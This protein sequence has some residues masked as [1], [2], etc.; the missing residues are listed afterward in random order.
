MSYDA[1]GASWGN[2]SA[3]GIAWVHGAT[4]P[5]DT[6]DDVDERRKLRKQD[7]DYS[8]ARDALRAQIQESFEIATG[9]ARIPEPAEVMA[10][11]KSVGQHSKAERPQLRRTILQIRNWQAE[12]A[13]IE[14]IMLALDEQDF[15]DLIALL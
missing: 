7:Q 5:V 9:E 8:E 12:L 14:R 11:E 6:H 1:W 10:L 3:W 13:D 15:A 4:K 2:P